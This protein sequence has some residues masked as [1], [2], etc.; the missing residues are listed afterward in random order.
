MPW[1]GVT[2]PDEAIAYGDTVQGGI[3]TG[4]RVTPS[5]IA[6]GGSRFAAALDQC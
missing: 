6:V 3:L 1:G 2:S 4:A 5:L